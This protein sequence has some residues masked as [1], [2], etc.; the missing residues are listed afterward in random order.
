M[1]PVHAHD[2]VFAWDEAAAY[3]AAARVVVISQWLD[4]FP[5]NRQMDPLAA[6]LLRYI[7]LFEEAGEMVGN[8]I[9]MTGQNPRKGVTSD[10][11]HV[12]EEASDSVITLLGAIEHATGN[13][14]ESFGRVFAKI[15]KVYAR[16]EA[17]QA[18]ADADLYAKVKAEAEA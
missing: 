5:V 11:E 8:I 9:G 12:L 2:D 10:L 16:M 14:G 13:R 6:F 15:A 18:S 3:D 1:S 7:K 17:H 4:D